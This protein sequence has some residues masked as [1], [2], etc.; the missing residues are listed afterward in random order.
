MSRRAFVAV[1]S[2]GVTPLARVLKCAFLAHCLPCAVPPNGAPNTPVSAHPRPCWAAQ[3]HAVNVAALFATVVQLAVV[4]GLSAVG[5]GVG[6]T[7]RAASAREAVFLRARDAVSSVNV[8][9]LAPSSHHALVAGDAVVAVVVV[10]AV[11]A[12]VSEYLIPSW[13]QCALPVCWVARQAPEPQ[14]AVLALGALGVVCAGLAGDAAECGV[15]EPI[16]SLAPGAYPISDFARRTHRYP[17]AR[18]AAHGAVAPGGASIALLACAGRCEAIAGCALQALVRGI[19]HAAPRN[20]VEAGSAEAPLAA[21]AVDAV[22]SRWLLSVRAL[23]AVPIAGI[24]RQAVGAR[25]AGQ[26]AVAV[27][28]RPAGVAPV[29][30]QLVPGSALEAVALVYV[31]AEAPHVG[32]IAAAV[33]HCSGALESRRGACALIS[34]VFPAVALLLEVNIPVPTQ[35]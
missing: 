18:L 8:A 34:A 21:S 14:H 30:G 35:C 11:P 19:A 6:G 32:A 31:T 4:A 22:S 2:L 10:A 24:A 15:V 17:R 16:A 7:Q 9:L 12:A 1:P 13:A 27:A 5:I 26:C 33:R 28:V 29:S 23:S 20:A 3:A 25:S